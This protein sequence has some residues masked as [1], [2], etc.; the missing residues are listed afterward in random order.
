MIAKR[1]NN[2]VARRFDDEAVLVPIRSRTSEPLA[3]HALGPVATFI[4]ESLD[5]AR[6]T[7]ALADLVSGEFEIDSAL[8]RHDV[9]AFLHQLSAAGLVELA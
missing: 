9:T 7:I 5:G 4:W 8:A 6:D 3:I 1:R 2:V